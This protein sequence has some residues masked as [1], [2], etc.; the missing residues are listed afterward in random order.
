[1]S[2]N[3]V[4]K[5][6]LFLGIG[7]AITILSQFI[8]NKHKINSSFINKI[9]TYVELSKCQELALKTG[10]EQIAK[11]SEHPFNNLG[12]LIISKKFY[13]V[14]PHNNSFTFYFNGSYAPLTIEVTHAIDTKIQ[15]D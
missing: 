15:L 4:I 2:K 11:N 12:K 6:S 1:M 5:S 8:Y 9:K 13:D 10:I 14:K 3:K 7:A